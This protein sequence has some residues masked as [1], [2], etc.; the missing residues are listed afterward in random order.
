MI[1]MARSDNVGGLL[2]LGIAYAVGKKAGSSGGQTDGYYDEFWDEFQ[3]NGNRTNY[4]YGF[5]GVGWTEK[6]FRPKYSIRPTGYATY[7]FAYNRAKVDLPALCS[8]LGITID[9][10]GAKNLNNAFYGSCFT[11]LGTIDVSGADNINYIFQEMSYL[12]E[13]EVLRLKA[14]GSNV[15][16]STF[17]NVPALTEIRIEGVIGQNGFNVSDSENLSKE[18]LLSIF[19][20]LQDKTGDTSETWEIT[21]GDANASKLTDVERNIAINKGWRIK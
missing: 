2:K 12:T 11:K 1:Y 5:G 8:E 7:I 20:A 21:I 16:K 4:M 3:N 6:T 13:I 10:S 15:F 18:S 17:Y 19:N 14:D 9:F